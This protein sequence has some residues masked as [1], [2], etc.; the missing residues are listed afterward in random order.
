M[1]TGVVSRCRLSGRMPLHFSAGSRVAGSS[2]RNNRG[3][4]EIAYVGAQHA[5]P[6]NRAW[7]R[8]TIR[9]SATL[10]GSAAH[11]ASDLPTPHRAQSAPADAPTT[12]TAKAAQEFFFSSARTSLATSF[13]VSK[14]PWP[15]TATASSDDSPLTTSSFRKSSTERILGKSRLLSCRT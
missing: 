1:R 10:T 7:Q 9:K 6:G 4:H 12:A 11:V 5:V 3:S 2:F 8:L 15:V 13:S 14:T